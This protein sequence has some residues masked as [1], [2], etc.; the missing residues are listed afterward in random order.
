MLAS[1]PGVEADTVRAAFFA[2]LR[3][4]LAEAETSPTAGRRTEE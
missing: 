1:V 2:Q 4:M 3:S